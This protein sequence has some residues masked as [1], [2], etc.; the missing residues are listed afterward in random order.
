VEEYAVPILTRHDDEV[1]VLTLGTGENRL[2]P[3]F[4]QQLHQAL[5]EVQKTPDTALVTV[6]EGKQY[7]S[8]L[9]LDLLSNPDN[10]GQADKYLA[11]VHEIL[12]RVLVFPAYTVAA[13]NGHAF[14]AGAMLAAAHD[15]RVMRED[16]GYWCLPEVDL[17]LPFAEGMMALLRAR[18]PAAALHHAMITGARFPAPEAVTAGIVEATAAAGDVLTT[19]IAQARSN[20]HKSRDVVQAIKRGLYGDAERKLHTAAQQAS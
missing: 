7:S 9:D 8:G 1:F 16:R 10:A 14:A 18:V 5:D 6:G 4:L 12:A 11:D 3:Q 17:G 19:A 20:A 13:L 15:Y 2:T